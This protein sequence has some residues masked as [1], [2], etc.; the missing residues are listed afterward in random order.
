M[1][2][3][4]I[5]ILWH[6][7]WAVVSVIWTLL[8]CN[9]AK[10]TKGLLCWHCNIPKRVE[11]ALSLSVQMAELKC[12]TNWLYSAITDSVQWLVLS[13]IM[14]S[15]IG[16]VLC[17]KCSDQRGLVNYWISF[18][19]LHLRNLR[20][21][22]RISSYVQLVASWSTHAITVITTYKLSLIME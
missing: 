18:I 12:C 14:T 10:I 7:I 17:L 22:H 8:K 9:N 4:S 13:Y 19:L 1:R 20:Q 2:Q 21:C 6:V 16:Y 11:W 3:G 5:N 15:F